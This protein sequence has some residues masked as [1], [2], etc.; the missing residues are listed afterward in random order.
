MA[1][2]FELGLGKA[3]AFE[4]GL[5]GLDEPPHPSRGKAAAPATPAV[6]TLRKSLLVNSFTFFLLSLGLLIK[7][8]ATS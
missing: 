1:K 7:K 2:K 6:P 4:L 8:N 5:V 3:K